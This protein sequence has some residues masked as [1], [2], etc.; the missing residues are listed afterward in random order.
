MTFDEFFSEFSEQVEFVKD[1]DDYGWE[2]QD[3][4]TSV[5]LDYLED[6]GEVESPVICPYRAYGADERICF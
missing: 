3:F 6:V 4:F 1:N 5:I 2:E